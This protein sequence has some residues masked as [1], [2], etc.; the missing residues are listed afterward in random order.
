MKNLFKDVNLKIG[1][2]VLASSSVLK[3]MIHNKN[4]KNE[5]DINSIIDMLI[6]KISAKIPYTVVDYNKIKD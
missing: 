1:D 6:E 3:I 2:A 5:I 4:S